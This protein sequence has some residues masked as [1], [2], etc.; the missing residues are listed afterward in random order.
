MAPGDTSP[1]QKSSTGVVT[2]TKIEILFRDI[3]T[4]LKS[5]MLRLSHGGLFI[6]T[7]NPLPLDTPVL[8]KITV[9]DNS[10][11]IE[12]EGIVVL[13]NPNAEKGYFPQGM[14]VKFSKINPEDEDRIITLTEK[15]KSL[16]EDLSI[17]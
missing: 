14:G 13:S 2:K 6:K 17:F 4:F 16:A 9:P 7:D 10:Q 1:S 15:N 5:Y 3:P 8:L 12:A 11:P